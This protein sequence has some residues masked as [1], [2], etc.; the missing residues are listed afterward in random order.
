MMYRA[1]ICYESNSW[2]V[3]DDKPEIKFSEPDIYKY[4]KIIPI[5][6]SV[7]HDCTDDELRK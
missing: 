5:S 1:W 6:F 4:S 2:F 3:D 7:L